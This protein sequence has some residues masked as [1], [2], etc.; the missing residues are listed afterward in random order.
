MLVI[1]VEFRSLIKQQTFTK[2]KR[3]IR[4]TGVEFEKVIQ[5]FVLSQEFNSFIS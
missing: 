1:E 4:K 2:K 5:K 3:K